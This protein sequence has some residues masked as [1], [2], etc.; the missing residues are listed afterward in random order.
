MIQ[1][2]DKSKKTII[3]EQKDSFNKSIAKKNTTISQL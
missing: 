1:K 2:I 3:E